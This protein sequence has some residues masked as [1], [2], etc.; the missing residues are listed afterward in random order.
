M[1]R[2]VHARITH[3]GLARR[4]ACICPRCPQ[5]MRRGTSQTSWALC[6]HHVPIT[7]NRCL[8]ALNTGVIRVCLVVLRYSCAIRTCKGNHCGAPLSNCNPVKTPKTSAANCVYGLSPADNNKPAA[9]PLLLTTCSNA[10]ITVDGAN[11]RLRRATHTFW[12][13]QEIERF[14]FKK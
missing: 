10:A 6:V 4:T 2:Y 5:H 12:N 13:I 11:P 14:L 9:V 3:A 8:S 7:S 1:R